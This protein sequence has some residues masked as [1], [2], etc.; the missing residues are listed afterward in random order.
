MD[1]E[2]AVNTADKMDALEGLLQLKPETDPHE[3]E[4]VDQ[5]MDPRLEQS[6]EVSE[7]IETGLEGPNLRKNRRVDIKDWSEES[8]DFA[9]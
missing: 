2:D 9:S 8:D 6:A 4:V 1:A 7:S 5:S 3:V